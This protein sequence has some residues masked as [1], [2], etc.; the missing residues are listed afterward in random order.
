MA[1]A[2]DRVQRYRPWRAENRRVEIKVVPVTQPGIEMIDQL[3]RVS[4]KDPELL[5]PPRPRD[6]AKHI[7][8]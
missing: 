5:P 8:R 6:A 1:N 3:R 2:S 4:K 7:G